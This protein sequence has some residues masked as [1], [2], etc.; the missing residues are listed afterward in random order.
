M[1]TQSY[2][3][4]VGAAEFTRGNNSFD[5]LVSNGDGSG[6]CGYGYTVVSGNG[7]EGGV[8]YAAAPQLLA[9]EEEVLEVPGILAVPVREQEMVVTVQAPTSLELSP[10]MAA[11]VE[12]E[13][14]LI[15]RHWWV[16]RRR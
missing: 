10:F 8:N 12:G 1:T 6:T 2:L 16:G 3:V 15:T 13:I 5:D 9:A 11:E 14:T 7:F 4:T